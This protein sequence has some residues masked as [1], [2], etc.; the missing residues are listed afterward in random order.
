MTI[1]FRILLAVSVLLLLGV[2][3]GLYAIYQV[4]SLG[5]VT[6]GVSSTPIATVNYSRTAWDRFRNS[7][8]Y[9][10]SRLQFTDEETGETLKKGLDERLLEVRKA[11][12]GIADV[13][14][15][16]EVKQHLKQVKVALTKWQQLASARLATQ[17]RQE[18]PA[19]HVM[20]A[21]EADLQQALDALVTTS[22]AVAKKTAES[23]DQK[24]SQAVR[25]AVVGMV[26]GLAFVIGLSLFLM[27]SVLAPVVQ[28]NRALVDLSRGE[29]DLSRRLKVR[30]EDELA[31]ASA[32]L[33]TFLEKIAGM[34]GQVNQATRDVHSESG[35]L[36]RFMSEVHESAGRQH[37]ESERIRAAVEDVSKAATDVN[38]NAEA[39]EAAAQQTD[40]QV[41]QALAVLEVA[42]TEIRSL[43]DL[44]D[45]GVSVISTVGRDST[46]IASA[47]TVIRDIAAQTN[48]LA[49]NAAIEAARAGEAGRGFAVVADEVRK[50]ASETEKSTAT[51]EAIIEK[52]HRGMQEA[53]ET[54]QAI[55]ARSQST[56]DQACEIDSSLQS[57]RSAVGNI[58]RMNVQIT[59]A[60]KE[61]TRLVAQVDTGIRQIVDISGKTAKDAEEASHGT[62]RISSRAQ[63]LE[64]LVGRFKTS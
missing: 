54:I 23:S 12:D 2:A 29:A 60:A 7:R 55:N 15:D 64:A 31:E 49:L 26:I 48:L 53:V 56:V 46:S 37:E 38:A 28:L 30:G 27:R 6:K 45:K 47:L 3:Q 39:A 50:L 1:K 41:M 43:A 8:D 59:G 25:L 14:H 63:E 35:A 9:L 4:E 52:L 40:G 11:L 58:A 20:D 57:V 19:D 36:T 13:A 22:I 17:P 42:V 51:I 10:Q 24:V 18:I 62:H 44:V 33:N 34:V 21:A 61:Q 32:A 16:D 5:Q